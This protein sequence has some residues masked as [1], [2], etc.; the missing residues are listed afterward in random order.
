MCCS[1]LLHVRLYIIFFYFLLND[2]ESRSFCPFPAFIAIIYCLSFIIDFFFS[3]FLFFYSF[4]LFLIFIVSLFPSSLYLFLSFPF[5]FITSFSFSFSFYSPISLSS[6][7][8]LS[9]SL[10]FIYP[11]HFHS[12]SPFPFLGFCICAVRPRHPLFNFQLFRKR[13][14][15]L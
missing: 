12:Y 13:F 3:R 1:F 15:T 9:M 11:S 5:S 14:R 6:F 10:P 8:F 2:L 7:L 4:V